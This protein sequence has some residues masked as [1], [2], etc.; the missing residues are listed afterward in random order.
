MNCAGRSASRRSSRCKTVTISPTARLRMCLLSVRKADLPSCLGIP[1]L[2]AA[3]RRGVVR[4][5]ASRAAEAQRP[6]KWQS[7]GCSPARVSLFPFPG[8]H[9]WRTLTRTSPPRGFCF[10]PKNCTNCP[11]TVASGNAGAEAIGSSRLANTALRTLVVPELKLFHR[12]HREPI[13]QLSCR[14]RC[15]RRTAFWQRASLGTELI[16]SGERHAPARGRAR[17]SRANRAECRAFFE[18]PYMSHRERT[19]WLGREDSNL[20]MAESKSTYFI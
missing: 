3:M 4:L 10:R 19:A 2:L 14:R 5:A 13:T 7:L 18:V 17:F 6:C 12:P 9:R 16:V 20:R 1:W 11:E 8:H 15:D